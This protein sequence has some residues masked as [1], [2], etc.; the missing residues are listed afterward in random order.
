MPINHVYVT[1]VRVSLRALPGAQCASSFGECCLTGV[2]H[3]VQQVSKYTLSA[4]GS[5]CMGGRDM[6]N[7]VQKLAIPP[8]PTCSEPDSTQGSNTHNDS[9][10]QAQSK[11]ALRLDN[12]DAPLFVR[13]V[14]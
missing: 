1:F 9:Q 14:E 11:Q 8:V 3:G 5:L 6:Q 2:A 7:T 10:L 4:T 12:P 13:H